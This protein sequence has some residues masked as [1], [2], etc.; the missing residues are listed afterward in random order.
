MSVELKGKK[1]TKHIQPRTEKK[2]RV[3]KSTEA[4]PACIEVLG[5]F[6]RKTQGGI[7]SPK[8]KEAFVGKKEQRVLVAAEEEK[9]KLRNLLLAQIAMMFLRSRKMKG[10]LQHLITNRLLWETIFRE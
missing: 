2:V 7:D 9:R 4:R 3:Q 1:K 5:C 8:W 10:I 6:P